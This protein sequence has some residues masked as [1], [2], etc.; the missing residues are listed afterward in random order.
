M[1]HPRKD[2]KLYGKLVT[3]TLQKR[4][5][6]TYIGEYE[7]NLAYVIGFEPNE[8]GTFPAKTC[9]VIDRGGSEILI[10]VRPEF[11][12]ASICYECNIIHELGTLYQ[13]GDI[14]YP[15]FERTCG[16]VMFTEKDGM[17]KYLLIR[18]ESGHIGFP[19]GHIDYGESEAETADREVYEE[20]GLT[21]EQYGD[22]REEYTYLTKEYT[23]KA[24]VFFIG[25]YDYREPTI[26][27]DEITDD[28]LLSYPDALRLLNFPEDR[29]LLCKAEK[30]ISERELNV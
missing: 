12:G 18:N 8:I 1:A 3:V 16:A 5:G 25:H 11:Y 2:H 19:K 9:A 22:F 23:V 17:R 20:T 14:L 7:Q 29:D 4:V 15:K 26:Q 10:M 30:Y 28:W 24:S 13:E 6:N 21:F 27:E